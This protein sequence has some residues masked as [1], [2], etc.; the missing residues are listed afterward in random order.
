MAVDFDEFPI[1]KE[2]VISVLGPN[3]RQSGDELIWQCP[4]CPGGD[5]HRDNLRYN[6]SKQVLKCFACDYASVIVGII[7]R[8]RYGATNVVPD[9]STPQTEKE[10][11]KPEQ[12]EIEQ[13]DLDNYY[14]E[15]NTALMK[16][17]VLLKAIFDKH[18]ILPRT[19]VNCLI[20]YD[21]VKDKIVFPS[22]AAGPNPTDFESTYANGAEYREYEG[23]K[24]VRRIKG[25]SS[26]I[27][28]VDI[29]FD[30]VKEAVICEGYKDAY[31]FIQLLKALQPEKLAYT[32][33]FTV[34]N[35][36]NSINAD[37]CLQK[38]NWKKFERVGLLMDNDEAGTTATQ[39]ARELF[40]FMED[41]R[42][43]YIYK[44]KDVQERFKKEITPLIDV[45]KM[46]QAD[47]LKEYQA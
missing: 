17:P 43:P 7:A 10:A 4:A 23:E 19:A 35:G 15:C 13:K 31:N 45:D 40:P 33:V 29:N 20:G 1:T 8:R 16:N 27:C 25:Y 2:E 26:K 28:R 36:T 9:W 14:F 24:T 6:V 12:K 11:P 42:I 46:L 44:Y 37:Q 21:I 41:W 47:W 5:K 38:I 18:T 30:R 34:Q 39:I 32:A 22:R 3:Y